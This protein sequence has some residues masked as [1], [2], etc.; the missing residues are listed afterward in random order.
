TTGSG[1]TNPTLVAIVSPALALGP[2]APARDRSA[3]GAIG[4]AARL[5]PPTPMPSGRSRGGHAVRGTPR[6]SPP[7]PLLRPVTCSGSGL[8]V[9]PGTAAGKLSVGWSSA[10]ES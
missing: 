6:V 10:I 9:V 4:T 2:L 1:E 7:A 8:G 5:P 3:A